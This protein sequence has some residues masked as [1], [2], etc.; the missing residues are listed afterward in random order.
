MQTYVAEIDLTKIGDVVII[1]PIASTGRHIF[2]YDGYMILEHAPVGVIGSNP[3]V[4]IGLDSDPDKV[5][6]KNL[7]LAWPDTRTDGF[8]FDIRVLDPTGEP[9]KL[10][11]HTPVLGPDGEKLQSMK[12]KLVLMAIPLV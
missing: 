12:A 9:L 2:L 1:P 3:G 4:S 5:V 10:Y 6:S 7:G 11:V 8:T